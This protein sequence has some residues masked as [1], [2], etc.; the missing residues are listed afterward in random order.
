MG[1]TTL[2]IG[3]ANW[4]LCDRFA[5]ANASFAMLGVLYFEDPQGTSEE[6]PMEHPNSILSPS[7]CL[8]CQVLAAGR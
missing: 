2:K 8:G 1:G 6:R 3:Y 7:S 5:T 4:L